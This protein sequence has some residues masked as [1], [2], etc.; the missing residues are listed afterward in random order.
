V[1]ER[2][3]EQIARTESVFR[4][5]NERIADSAG[6]F[7]GDE[8]AF[9]CEC[10]DPACTER[11]DLPLEE[12]EDVREEGTRFVVAHGHEDERVETVVR[13]E[14]EHQVV[15][16]SRNALVKRIVRRLDPRTATT[17]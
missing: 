1:N 4:E 14:P 11:V 17:S 12:Y 7:D 16:K 10:A 8:A 5:V 9:V 2:E 3:A 13:H 6:R 15:E